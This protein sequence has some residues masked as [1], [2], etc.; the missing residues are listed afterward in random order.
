MDSSDPRIGAV[1]TANE[2][3]AL[4]NQALEDAVQAARAGG[5]TWQVIGA[6]MG[7]TKQ[8]AAQRFSDS[9]YNARSLSQIQVELEQITE[10]L[11]AALAHSD[12]EHVHSHMTYTTARLLSKRKILKTWQQV[13]EVAGPFIEVKKTVVEQAG[14]GFTLTYRLR[15]E[16][17]E[18]VGQLSF[19]SAR[20]VTGL[21]IFNDDSAELSW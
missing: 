3:V 6:A 2:Q 18:P 17:G 9:V 10:A 8:A 7:V 16:H 5:A 13:L 19:N 11:F 21:V 1:R 20:K 14:S 12:I 15:H 4:A